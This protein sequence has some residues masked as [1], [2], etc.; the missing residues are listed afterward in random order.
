MSTQTAVDAPVTARPS[1]G[2]V[3]GPVMA[4]W[5]VVEAKWTWYRRSW[6]ATVGSSVLMP[7]LFLIALGFGFGTRCGWAPPP[8]G[9]R[10]V[11]YLAPALLASAAVQNAASES[12][13][14][15]LAGFKWQR[16]YLG[17]ASTPVTRTG[18]SR[19]SSSG[20]CCGWRSP[21]RCTCWS[22]SRWAP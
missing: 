13:F 5:L 11:I 22:P 19:A 14:P 9:L 15:V 6:R 1:T 21:A 7:L 12:T 2:R 3:V 20:S 16:L 17:I 4:A 10:Y 18:S 8:S